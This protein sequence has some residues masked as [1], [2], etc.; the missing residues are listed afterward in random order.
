MTQYDFDLVLPSREPD[1]HRVWMPTDC[2]LR[3]LRWTTS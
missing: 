1:K 3:E 2:Y